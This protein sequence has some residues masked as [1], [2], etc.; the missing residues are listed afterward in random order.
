MTRLRGRRRHRFGGAQGGIRRG[1]RREKRRQGRETDRGKKE[2]G[3]GE[4]A[5]LMAERVD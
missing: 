4:R 5:R 3:G 2:R 1:W